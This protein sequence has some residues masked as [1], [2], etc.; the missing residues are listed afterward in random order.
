[1]NGKTLTG[2]IT[3]NTTAAGTITLGSGTLSG[4]L[5]VNTPNASFVNNAA[6]TGSTTIT[7][8]ANSTFTNNGTLT[9]LV[10]VTDTSARIV[11]NGTL[12][13]GLNINQAVAGTIK[14]EGNFAKVTVSKPTT[15]TL[16][17]TITALDATEAPVVVEGGTITGSTGTVVKSDA[18]VATVSSVEA[19]N[20][21]IANENFTEIKLGASFESSKPV[22]LNRNI[23]LDGNGNVL[24]FTSTADGKNTGEGLYISKTATV[25]N[26]TV[27]AAAGFKD[28][29]VEVM[30]VGA[31]AK[32]VDVTIEG[33]KQAAIY[34]GDSQNTGKKEILTVEGTITLIN[35]VWGGIGVKNGSIV[36]LTK[37][38]VAYEGAKISIYNDETK[39]VKADVNPVAWEDSSDVTVKLP[40]T[41]YTSYGIYK[42]GSD[43][44]LANAENAATQNIHTK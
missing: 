17:G 5:T 35:N 30:G 4:N 11:N 44:I 33:S 1:M 41:G 6:V 20:M 34:V 19:L 9:G 8:V 39:V 25:K 37:A 32:L 21:A 24:T 29:L 36:D 3:Y 31:D 27:K 10:T 7:D 43:R 22:H 2:N 28:N 13:A 38:T 14:L 40:V 23:N 12:T 18:G 15:I 26:L 16:A 42:L